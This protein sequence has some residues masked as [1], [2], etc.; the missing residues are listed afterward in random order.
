MNNKIGQRS[1]LAE[2]EAEWEQLT[3]QALADEA[4][5]LKNAL[6]KNVYICR[7]LNRQARRRELEQQA[8]AVI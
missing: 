8:L 5:V 4:A 3:A 2:L 1:L 7:D 6:D